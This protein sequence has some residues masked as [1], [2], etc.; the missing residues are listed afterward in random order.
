MTNAGYMVT[1]PEYIASWAN[2]L[3]GRRMIYIYIYIYDSISMGSPSQVYSCAFDG[4][5]VLARADSS[6]KRELKQRK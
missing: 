2:S 1:E 5:L 6:V 4:V 3:I